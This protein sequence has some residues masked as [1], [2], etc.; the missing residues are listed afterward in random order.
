[1]RNFTAAAAAAAAAGDSSDQGPLAADSSSTEQQHQEQQQHSSKHGQQPRQQKAVPIRIAATTDEETYSLE[2]TK[3]GFCEMLCY[4]CLCLGSKAE[5]MLLLLQISCVTATE[6]M[7]YYGLDILLSTPIAALQ[8]P[9][10]YPA[11]LTFHVC[12]LCWLW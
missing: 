8:Q 2:D 1:M 4:T 10:L 6:G 3:V 7:V 5:V 9:H 12:C 11:T